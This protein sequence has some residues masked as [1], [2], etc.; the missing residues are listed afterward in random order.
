ME[1]KGRLIDIHAREIFNSVISINGG[2]IAGIERSVNEVP[3]YYIMPGLID[4]HVHI[5][6][7][8]ISP[9]S[10]AMASVPH[11]TI[12]VVS[13]PHEIAN[14]MGMEGIEFMLEDGKKT[15]FHFWFG[16]PSCVPA[17][18]LETSG[19][20]IGPEEVEALLKRDEI[21]FLAE[22]MNFPGVINGNSEVIAKLALA[23]K[24]GKPVDGH[25]PALTGEVLRKY[26]S[27]GISTDHECSSVEEAI[28]KIILGMKVI[29]REGS[30][31]R[32]LAALKSLYNDYPDMIMLGSDDIHPEMLRERHLEKLIAQLIDEGYNIFDVI[33]SAT[34]NPVEHYKLDAGILRTGDPADFIIVDDPE[35][36]NVIETWIMGEKVFDRGKVFFDYKPAEPLNKFNCSKLSKIEI[37]VPQQKNEMRVIASFDGELFTK[38]LLYE[39]TPGDLVESDIN[40]DILKIVVKDRYNDAPP[41]VGFIK[42]FSLKSGAFASSVAHDSHNIIAVGTSDEDI[43]LAINEIVRIKGGLSVCDRGLVNS[44]QLNIAGIMSNR[45]C[46]EVADDYERLSEQVK[47]MGCSMSAPFMTLSF[48]ALLVIPELKISDRGLFDGNR[49]QYVPLFV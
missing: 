6:S 4:A 38:E 17:T 28:E 39:P 5:E 14:V 25:A 29:I 21:K 23:E 36:M 26:I 15:P 48:M 11:G 19:A 18:E 7:S 37:T 3:E 20:K 41:A 40:E 27:A 33:R 24:Y 9:G 22:M 46:G 16:A 2:R 30:A 32:N 31:G 1:I 42:G 34:V 49:F 12:G 35:R 8:M 45:P 44:L 10:F 43:L 47:K 13:D